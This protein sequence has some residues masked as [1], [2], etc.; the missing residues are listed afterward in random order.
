MAHILIAEDD[1]TLAELLKDHLTRKNFLVT[2]VND[3]FSLQQKARD[4]RPALIIA[5]VLMPGAYGST[6]YQVLQKDHYTA[7]IP[8]IFISAVPYEKLKT[9]LPEDPKTRYFKKPLELKEL[10]RAISELLP[11]GAPPK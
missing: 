9:V 1:A 8:I 6:V 4:D 11:K 5:D 7:E 10:D 3:G 2:V